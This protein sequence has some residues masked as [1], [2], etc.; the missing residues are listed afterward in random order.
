MVR[1]EKQRIWEKTEEMKMACFL[2]QS[3]IY[4]LGNIGFDGR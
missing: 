2:S 1:T 3:V 4:L